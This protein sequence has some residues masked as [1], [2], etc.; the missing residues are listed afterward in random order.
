MCVSVEGYQV[1]CLDYYF[2]KSLGWDVAGWYHPTIGIIK[3]VRRQL[4]GRFILSGAGAR[5]L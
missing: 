1:Y 5:R 2:A 4:V 3:R